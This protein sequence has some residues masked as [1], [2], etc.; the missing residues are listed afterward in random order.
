[1]K[2]SKPINTQA[3]IAA[4]QNGLSLTVIATMNETDVKV[5]KRVLAEAGIALRKRDPKAWMRCWH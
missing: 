5:V 3:I 4:Y 1:M 2:K